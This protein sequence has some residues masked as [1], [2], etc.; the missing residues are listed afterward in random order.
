[1]RSQLAS[2]RMLVQMKLNCHYFEEINFRLK[3][4]K[5]ASKWRVWMWKGKWKLY[6]KAIKR[7][8]R[9]MVFIVVGFFFVFFCRQNVCRKCV[10]YM[11]GWEFIDFEIV[12]LGANRFL[13]YRV[14][15]LIERRKNAWNDFLI[16]HIMYFE[17]EIDSF[18]IIIIIYIRWESREALGT[19]M[20]DTLSGNL[21]AESQVINLEKSLSHHAAF[22]WAIMA[23]MGSIH[24]FCT[25]GQLL[26]KS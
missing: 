20:G 9:R 3:Q 13:S 2:L 7:A 26:K 23:I 18:E 5:H 1:M 11:R 16:G 6:I 21:R 15:L 19:E 22:V 12:I 4:F 14:V 24:V 17:S 8:R 25:L 10:G